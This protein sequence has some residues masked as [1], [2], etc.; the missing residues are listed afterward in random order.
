MEETTIGRADAATRS[1]ER[2]AKR[3]RIN[4]GRR[5]LLRRAGEKETLALTLLCALD[6]YTT[7]WWV[8]TGRAV[9]GNKFIAWTFRY[10][11]VVFVLV[12]CATCLPALLGAPYLARRHPKTT[13]WLLRGIFIAYVALYFGNVQWS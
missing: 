5:F 13:V 10:D 3:F 6:M 4:F 2:R 7:L 11:P 12:K 8:I 9:E 1:A